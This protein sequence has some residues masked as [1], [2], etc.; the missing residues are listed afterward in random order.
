M[1]QKQKK[2]Q[3]DTLDYFLSITFYTLIYKSY[4]LVNL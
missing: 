2:R 4:L 1:K 3:G